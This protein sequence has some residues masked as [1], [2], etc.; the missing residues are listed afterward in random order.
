MDTRLQAKKKEQ[1]KKEKA[2]KLSKFFGKVFCC[3]T[4]KICG[5]NYIYVVG[6]LV[7]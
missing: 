1:K 6:D 2:F 3:W 7:R 4:E 5:G